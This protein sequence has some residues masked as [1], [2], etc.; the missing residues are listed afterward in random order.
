[1]AEA[2]GWTLAVIDRLSVYQVQALG[3]AS[4]RIAEKRK[5]RED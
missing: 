4:A 2:Y 1:M 5:P 3:A